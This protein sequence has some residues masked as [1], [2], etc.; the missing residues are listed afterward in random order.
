MRGFAESLTP[1]DYESYLE[2]FHPEVEA[3]D[4]AHLP[5]MPEMLRGRAAIAEVFERWMEQLDDWEVGVSDYVDAEPWVVCGMHWRAT[6][7]GSG[8]PIEW[9]LA[10]AY[11]LRDGKIVRVI[12]GFPD[13]PT[14]LKALESTD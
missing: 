3:R 7:K 4:L 6:G 12:F 2:L 14:A 9:R 11:D 5:D 10:D 8:V 13:I 1:G